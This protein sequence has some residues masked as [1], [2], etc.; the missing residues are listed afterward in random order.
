M[1]GTHS[2][3][4]TNKY[5]I[6]LITSNE[7]T[8]VVAHRMERITGPVSKLDN[9]VIKELF[10]YCDLCLLRR[11]SSSV[12]AL[13]DNVYYG[14]HPKKEIAKYGDYLSI[15][16]SELGICLQGSHPRLAELAEIS[17]SVVEMH[18]LDR[19]ENMLQL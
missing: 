6:Q 16:D 5:D 9:M 19:C 2:K 8:H 18:I 4:T 14:L 11:K 17:A 12:D 3:Y 13:L 10:P 7:V 1:G 15:M